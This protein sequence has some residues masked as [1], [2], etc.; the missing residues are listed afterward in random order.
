VKSALIEELHYHEVR[1]SEL[2]VYLSTN[3]VGGG[4]AAVNLGTPTDRFDLI[5]EAAKVGLRTVWCRGAEATHMHLI[6][7]KLVRGKMWQGSLF[8]EPNPKL[9]AISIVKEEINK[10]FGRFKLRSGATLYANDFY[11]DS[12]NNYDVCDIR[13]K[14]C[15]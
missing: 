3:G 8:D 12:A 11:A 1:A 7:S 6:A 5:S 14:F 10:K 13:G 15:F 9:E 4:G 2:T